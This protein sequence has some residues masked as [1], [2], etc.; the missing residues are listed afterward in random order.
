ME[1]KKISEAGLA[2]QFIKCSNKAELSAE[3]SD[4]FVKPCCL[5]NNYTKTND[6]S[7]FIKGLLANDEFKAVLSG[8]LSSYF[9]AKTAEPEDVETAPETAPETDSDE[10]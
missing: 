6:L 7:G 2:E 8:A 10:V 9:T 3:L 5:T 1:Y 4:C